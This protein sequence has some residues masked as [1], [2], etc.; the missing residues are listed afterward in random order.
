MIGNR[1]IDFQVSLNDGKYTYI[2]YKS[3]RHEALRYGESWR[4]L[5]GDGFIMALGQKIEQLI[6]A[7]NEAAPP[8]ELRDFQDKV[9]QTVMDMTGANVDGLAAIRETG[10]N[11]R[12]RKSNKGW[13]I[14]WMSNTIYVKSWAI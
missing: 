14:C 5:T 11:L 6:A 13:R 4:D 9:R 10:A 12:W 2:L 3:G 8:K 1:E 7:L